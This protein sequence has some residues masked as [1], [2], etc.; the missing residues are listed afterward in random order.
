[1]LG[2]QNIVSG[3]DCSFPLPDRPY[4]RKR[5]GRLAAQVGLLDVGVVAQFL[6]R[7]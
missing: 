5:A 3:S 6:G 4:R 7:P 2:V 1:L